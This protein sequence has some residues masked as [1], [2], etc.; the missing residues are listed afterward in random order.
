MMRH[1]LLIQVIAAL[2]LPSPARASGS[3]SWWTESAAPGLL[4][5][6]AS[7]ELFWLTFLVSGGKGGLPLNNSRTPASTRVTKNGF[8]LLRALVLSFHNWWFSFFLQAISTQNNSP[9]RSFP[10]P[11][12]NKDIHFTLLKPIAKTMMIVQVSRLWKI[13]IDT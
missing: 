10:D 1:K 8:E 4:D 3:S 13:E 12:I 9:F 5:S 11:V 6:P 2:L 7:Q